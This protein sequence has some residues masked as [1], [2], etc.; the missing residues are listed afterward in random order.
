MQEGLWQAARD[1]ALPVSL[2]LLASQA[3]VAYDLAGKEPD[4]TFVID[5][6]GAKAFHDGT[7]ARALALLGT[8]PNTWVKLLALGM[9]SHEGYP[10]RDLWPLYECA[11][12]H[13]GARRIVF[14]TDFPHL[15]KSTYDQAITWLDQLPFLDDDARRAIGAV[16]VA[17]LFGFTTAHGAPASC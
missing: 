1:L 2:Q 16:N 5:Y 3:K 17:T 13:F 12:Q 6:L 7:G 15:T 10:F 14:G 8:R 9:D 11:L 4:L